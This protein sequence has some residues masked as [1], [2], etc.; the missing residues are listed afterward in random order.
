MFELVE[1]LCVLASNRQLNDLKRFCCNQKEFKLLTVDPTFD[2]GTLNVTP[3]SY[4]HLL[5]ETRNEGKHPTLIGP[6]LISE[7]KT[8]EIYSTFC[9]TLKSLEPGLSNLM[10][11]GTDGEKA[12]ENAFNLNFERSVH[13]LCEIHLK[14]NIERKLIAL[15]IQGAT[16]DNIISDVFGHRKGEVYEIG[17]S[18]AASENDFSQQLAILEKR[19]KDAH[20]NG[21][22]FYA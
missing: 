4:Q 15:G 13:L 1:S 20:E 16:K 18:D 14:K 10:A 5:L 8:E 2:I 9:S 3:I 17:L 6:V 21:H 11:F 22:D 12:L 19:W 7:K